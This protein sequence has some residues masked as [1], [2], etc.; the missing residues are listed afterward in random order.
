MAK[1]LRFKMT[2]M[3][4]PEQYDVFWGERQVAYVRLRHGSLTVRCPDVGGELV[5]EAEPEGDG[6]FEKKER[7]QYLR[8]CAAAVWRFWN[9]STR[10]RNRFPA[11]KNTG[12]IMTMRPMSLMN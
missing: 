4:C 7:D 1:K 12:S 3:A 8:R 6:C 5:Y 10:I 2:G 9:G 11:W